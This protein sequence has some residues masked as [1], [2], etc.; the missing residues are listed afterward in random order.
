MADIKVITSDF[1]NLHISTS[2]NEILFS[3]KRFP[4]DIN[5]SDLKVGVIIE[6]K[7][8]TGKIIV[9][10]QHI[11]FFNRHWFKTS[12]IRESSF[13]ITFRYKNISFHSS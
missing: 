10:F 6:Q 9:I 7:F 12:E 4:K 2:K 11:F 5:V 13:A 3:E 8:V 1:V